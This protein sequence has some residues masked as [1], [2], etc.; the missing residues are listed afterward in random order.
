VDLRHGG[1]AFSHRRR[2]ALGGARPNIADG[3]NVG[4]TGLKLEDRPAVTVNPASGV[5]P[6]HYEA[7]FVHRNA[8]IQPSGIRVGANEQE[9]MAQGARMGVARLTITEYRCSEASALVSL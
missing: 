8:A 7:F 1:G 6:G 5:C 4:V 3:K 2:N 9:E